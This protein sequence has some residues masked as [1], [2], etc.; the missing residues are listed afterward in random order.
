MIASYLGIT[1]VH[2]SNLKKRRKT[3][4]GIATSN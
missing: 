3:V 1:P 2:F 4:K